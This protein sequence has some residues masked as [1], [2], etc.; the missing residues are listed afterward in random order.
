MQQFFDFLTQSQ[1]GDAFG[2]AL[3][4][5]LGYLFVLWVA[6]IIWVAR[7]SV[8]RSRNLIF[9]VVTILLVILL[10]IFG[11][12]IY[13]I[14]RPQKTLVEKYHEDIERKALAE[15]EEACHHCSRPLPLE[16]QYCPAC[17]T[18]ARNA[19]KHCKKLVSKGWSIC[20]YCGDRKEVTEKKD[21]SHK[22]HKPS[23]K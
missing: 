8:G 19:C 2:A 10:N 14:I 1:G 18:E 15:L 4:V 23:D 12:V 5:L 22:K 17:G 21:A 9:Q 7:D 11:L 16:F 20:P 3:K 13:L 6:L